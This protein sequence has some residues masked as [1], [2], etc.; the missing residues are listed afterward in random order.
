MDSAETPAAPGRANSGLRVFLI[1]WSVIAFVFGGLALWS[2]LAPF[3]GAVIASGQVSVETRQ[4]AVQHLEG[5]IVAGIHVTEGRRVEEGEL[6]IRLDGTAIQAGLDNIDAA[7]ADLIAREGR[8]LA[9]RDDEAELQVRALTPALAALP[10]LGDT[11]TSHG[12][13]LTARADSRATRV[14]ILRQRISQ[15]REKQVGLIAQVAAKDRQL[16]YLADEIDGLETLLDQGLA[17][18]TQLFALY[19]ERTAIAGEIESL[20]AEIAATDVQIG[21]ADLEILSLT[22]GFREEVI[23]EL[24]EVQ[25]EL[26]RLLSERTAAVDRLARLDIRAPRSGLALGVRAHTVGGVIA[27]AEP[28]LHIV[29]EGDPLVSMV[30]VLPQDIDK[31][32]VGQT[33]RLRFTAFSQD[34]TPEV[35]ATVKTVSGDAVIDESTGMPYYDVIIELPSQAPFG[36][37]FPIVPGMPVDAM[38]TT[39]SRNVLSYLTKPLT[40]SMSR[41]W[42]E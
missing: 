28:I 30:R 13:L 9:E 33:A 3:E 23:A 18:K 1:G 6:L 31:I 38:L 5:G 21:E 22:D 41:T 7:L 8:L 10:G 15:L 40:D 16:T 25:T 32:A 34:E 42:R 4:K 26:A 27:A 17:P 20:R 2:V 19:R 11:I 39:E 35:S 24:T 14:R 29:P 37:D 12:R 36:V